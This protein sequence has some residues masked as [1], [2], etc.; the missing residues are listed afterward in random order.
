M[1]T[2]NQS[3]IILLSFFIVFIIQNTGLSSYITQILALLII[4]SVIF[5]VIQRRKNKV[6]PAGKHAEELFIGS[7]REV[8]AVTTGIM[9]TVFLTGGIQSN[10]FFLLY[11]LLFGIAFLFEPPTVFVFMVGLIAVFIQGVFN[12]DVFS[13]FI[14]L[15]SL[16]FLSPLAFFFGNEFK[17]REKLEEEIEEKTGEIIEDADELLHS[18]EATQN[19]EDIEK[20]DD[21]LEKTNEL[22]KANK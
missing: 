3:L 13:N 5:I 10:L 18:N 16:I 22:R 20:L 8:F 1:K 17:R 6:L 4:F 9:L 15:G 19:P 14:K 7:N 2:L 12:D 21:I 11:F